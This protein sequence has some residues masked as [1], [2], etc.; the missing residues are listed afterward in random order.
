VRKPDA[1][2]QALGQLRELREAADR[3]RTAAALPVHLTN[4]SGAVV[5][6]AAEMAGNSGEQ[7]LSADLVEAFRRIVR[8]PVKL[9]PGCRALSNI[10]EALVKLEVPAAEVF[11]QGI[12]HQQWEASWGQQID[13]APPLR[14]ICAAGLVRMNDPDPLLACCE[15]LSDHAAD[16]RIGALRALGDSGHADAELLLRFKAR[17]RD[18]K[19]DVTAGCFAALLRLGP[20]ARAIPF[21]AGFLESADD[22]IAEG[23]AL[24]LGDSRL[25]EVVPRLL[26]AFAKR[27]SRAGG[28][29]WALSLSRQEAAL[30]FVIEQL[31]SGPIRT[32]A[33]ALEALALFKGD[34]QQRAKVRS[35][36]N[37]RG[38][39]ALE[40][41]WRQKWL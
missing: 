3:E 9:D 28:L 24:A 10:A 21:V 38:E 35:V 8:D 23:A 27:A 15:L 19:F 4:R 13:T 7:R 34:E 20:R 31:R 16:A 11:C 37:E 26:E 29:L 17:E 22:E 6:R 14:A 5:A 33:F 39:P 1:T 2:E 30:E 12:R 41:T 25:P 40:T 18:E 32:A 36:V